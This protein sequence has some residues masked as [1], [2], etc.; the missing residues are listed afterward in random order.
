MAKKQDKIATSRLERAGKLMGAGAKVGGNYLKHYAKKLVSAETSQEE[1]DEANAQDIYEALSSLK[2]GP[3]KVAQMLS[4]ADDVLPRAFQDQFSMAQKNV[5]PLSYPLIRQTFRKNLGKY[6]EDIF[7]DFTREAVNAASIGQVHKGRIGDQWFGIKIQY[8]GVGDSVKSDLRMVKPMAVRILGLNA[9]EIEPYMQEVESKLMEETDYILEVEQSQA[10]SE[11]CKDLP[12][13]VFPE[14]F[15]ELSGKR[16]ITMTW[17]EGLALTDWIATE[18][19]QEARNRIGQRLWDFY[20][21]QI[22]Q[23]RAFHADP[24]PGNFLV[25]PETELGVIDFGCVKTMPDFLYPLYLKITEP[26]ML[27][28]E[29]KLVPVLEQLELLSEKDSDR[30]KDLVIE[31]FTRMFSLIMRPLHSQTFDFGDEEFFQSIYKTGEKF[32]KDK[33][34]KRISARGSR[35]LVYFNRTYFGLFQLLHLLKAN[36]STEQPL[37]QNH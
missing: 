26:G 24:H 10:I 6:P 32:S 16:I 14:Y 29:E 30:E 11:A 12:G 9:K 25:T 15:P 36:I 23:L 22:H 17:L 18:P 7:E 37:I 3:L 35:H 31:V 8:P 5:T 27:E 4:M 1:L 20:Q 28:E 34:I 21:F 13:V 33:E 19:S 2:G